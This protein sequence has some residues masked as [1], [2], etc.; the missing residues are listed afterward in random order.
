MVKSATLHA[1]IRLRFETSGSRYEILS[2]FCCGEST[3]KLCK[4]IFDMEMQAMDRICYQFTFLLAK[5]NCYKMKWFL[6]EE[7]ADLVDG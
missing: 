6:L 3:A 5:T 4:T 1:G 7:L 2:L